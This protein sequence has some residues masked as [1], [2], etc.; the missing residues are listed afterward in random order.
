M[1]ETFI[2]APHL[3]NGHCKNKH[4]NVKSTDFEI[5]SKKLTCNVA[6]SCNVLHSFR[7]FTHGDCSEG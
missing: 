6:S 1:Y 7:S 3:Q 4:T 5:I 2:L